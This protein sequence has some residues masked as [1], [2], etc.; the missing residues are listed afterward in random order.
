MECSVFGVGGSRL[1]VIRVGFGVDHGRGGCC[2]LKLTRRKCEYF[3]RGS[4]R[5]YVDC[6][7]RLSLSYEDI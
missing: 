1:S 7:E 6:G 3:F 2:C 5:K 4:L